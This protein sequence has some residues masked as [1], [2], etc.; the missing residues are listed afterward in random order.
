MCFNKYWLFL[1]FAPQ[2]NSA[3]RN[4]SSKKI[5]INQNEENRCWGDAQRYNIASSS[6]IWLINKLYKVHF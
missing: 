2:N 6:L 3:F 5:E 1:S 4:K